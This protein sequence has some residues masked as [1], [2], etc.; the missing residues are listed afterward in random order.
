MA[1]VWER[2]WTTASGEEKAAWVADYFAPGKDGVRRRHIKTLDRKKDASAYLASV[3]RKGW[4]G[5]RRRARLATQADT[6]A[7]SP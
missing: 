7:F 4:L 2:K 1:K 5:D 6:A 3:P